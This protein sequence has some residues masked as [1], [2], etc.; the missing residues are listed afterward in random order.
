MGEGHLYK[1][2]FSAV[3]NQNIAFDPEGLLSTIPAIA[4]VIFGYLAGKYI[5][6]KGNTYEMIS[7]LLLAGLVSIFIALCWNIIFPINKPIWSSSYVLYTTGLAL[8]ILAIIIFLV[9][10]KG[11]QR[12][13]K[14]F[15]LFGKNPLLIYALSG[16]LV[17]IYGLILIGDTNA[18]GALYQYVFQPLAG[19]FV[20]SLLFAIAHVLL[21][22]AVAWFLDRKRIYLKV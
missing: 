8:S 7:H 4:S 20:G 22:L 9:D 13:T 2:Y 3:L 5:K 18:Y 6:E 19:N 14:P 12:W 1:G 21:F 16:I 11:R 15:V 10:L 17:R